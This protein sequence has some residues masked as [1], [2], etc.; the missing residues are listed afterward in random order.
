MRISELDTEDL[1][2]RL[3]IYANRTSTRKTQIMDELHAR[4]LQDDA[5]R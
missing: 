1:N 4:A 2:Q 3:D 5:I